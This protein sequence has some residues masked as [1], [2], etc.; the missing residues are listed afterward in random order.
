MRPVDLVQR[1]LDAYNAQD[2][3]AFCAG[4]SGDIRIERA[5][6]ATLSQ[7]MQEESSPHPSI[8]LEE[9]TLP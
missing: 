5:L 9:V 8:A 3:E 1:Q 4:C 6:G 2:V 7:G